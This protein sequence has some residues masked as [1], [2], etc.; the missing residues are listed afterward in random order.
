MPRAARFDLDRAQPVQ[1]AAGDD[2][3]A[4]AVGAG[5]HDHQ[6]ARARPPDPVEVA[7][8]AAQGAAHIGEGPL[9]Q[10]LAV[11]TLARWSQP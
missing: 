9:G 3:A 2:L 8:L 5:Q 1:H 4:G 11:A 10:L 7:Q 6:L